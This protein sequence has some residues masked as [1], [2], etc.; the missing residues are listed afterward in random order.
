MFP[1]P[2]SKLL[3]AKVIGK[4][5]E[6]YKLCEKLKSYKEQYRHFKRYNIENP[7]R[8]MISKSKFYRKKKMIDAEE[9]MHFKVYKTI[10]M[11]QEIKARKMERNAGYGFASFISNN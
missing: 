2:G 9:Y 4:F 8:K 1:P 11:I 5:T 7:S 10:Y 3:N 6:I